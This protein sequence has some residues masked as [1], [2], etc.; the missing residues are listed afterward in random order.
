MRIRNELVKD[1]TKKEIQTEQLMFNKDIHDMHREMESLSYK[2]KMN[3]LRRKRREVIEKVKDI[4]KSMSDIYDSEVK[5][6]ELRRNECML[7][8]IEHVLG[9]VKRN[10]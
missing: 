4:D 1:K 10:K 7:N 5:K 6:L 9:S 2:E 3:Y 8:K